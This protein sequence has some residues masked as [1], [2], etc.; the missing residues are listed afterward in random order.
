MTLDSLDK[1][2]T[3]SCCSGHSEKPSDTNAP[4]PETVIDPVRGMT[5]T[6]GNTKAAKHGAPTAQG[7]LQSGE[8][9]TLTVLNTEANAAGLA[10]NRVTAAIRD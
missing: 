2:S 4:A 3:S 9:F 7:F 1:T 8:E 6:L 10:I 5:V